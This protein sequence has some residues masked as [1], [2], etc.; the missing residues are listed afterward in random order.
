[1]N[2]KVLGA[3]GVSALLLTNGWYVTR[4]MENKPD[5]TRDPVLKLL[6]VYADYDDTQYNKVKVASV[7]TVKVVTSIPP[8]VGKT[9]VPVQKPKQDSKELEKLKVVSAINKYLAGGLL[10]NKGEVYYDAGKKN[11]VNSMLMASISWHETATESGKGAWVPGTSKVLREL[12]NVAG[13][14]RRTGFPFKGRYT[15]Y[16]GGI[17]ESIYDMAVLLKTVY[18]DAGKG[19]IQS[20]GQVWAPLDDYENGKYGMENAGW[21]GSV[22]EKYSKILE[23][24]SK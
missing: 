3:L 22:L 12:N 13:I 10:A 5:T 11:K 2:K 17:N 9:P 23:E 15:W 21:A 1:M 4:C 8:S 7:T 20:I 19:D 16:K 6:T 14:N 18:I 24:A